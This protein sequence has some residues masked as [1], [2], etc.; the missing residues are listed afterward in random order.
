MVIC[1]GHR[2]GERTIVDVLR[3]VQ[4]PFD[5]K[6]TVEE[7]AALLKEYRLREVVGDNYSA[8]WCETAFKAAGIRY[9]RCESPKG[10]LY[11]EGLPSFTRRTISIPHNA[12]LIRELKLLERRT[13]VG[14]RDTVDHGRTGSDDLAN[15]IFGLLNIVGKLKQGLRMFT[16]APP[17][18]NG[19]IPVQR[20]FDLKNGGFVPLPDQCGIVLHDVDQMGNLLRTRRV[21]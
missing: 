14:G 15:S 9:T 6:E 8:A 5:P 2:E 12:K 1:I 17:Y 20:E 21:R 18:L 3:G 10:K 11:T 19:D 13:H 7:F 16:L 4:P